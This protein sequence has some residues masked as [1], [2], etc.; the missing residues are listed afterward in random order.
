MSDYG[1]LKPFQITNKSKREF[2]E[3]FSDREIT[4]LK[5]IFIQLKR[6]ILSD[7]KYKYLLSFL[8]IYRYKKKVKSAFD[9]ARSNNPKFEVSENKHSNTKSNWHGQ[10]L[11]TLSKMCWKKYFLIQF[12]F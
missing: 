3:E 8:F 6:D 12:N 11:I 4:I 1:F 2:L 10:K 5:K 7:T 9:L